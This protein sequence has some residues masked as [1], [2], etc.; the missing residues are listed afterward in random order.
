MTITKQHLPNRDHT[1]VELRGELG[2]TGTAALRE[3]LLK[4]LHHSA[5]LLVLDL[6]AVSRCDAPALAVLVGTQR[7]AKLLGITL[8]LAAPRPDFMR[9]LRLTDLDRSLAIHPTLA[10][11]LSRP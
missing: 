6:S 10:R 1:V 8:R 3:R 7:R 4:V 9:L 2:G 11:A 5:K